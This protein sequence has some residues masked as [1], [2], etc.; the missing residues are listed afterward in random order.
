MTKNLIRLIGIFAGLLVAFITPVKSLYADTD[1]V[2]TGAGVHFVWVIF[3]RLNCDLE[4]VS[5][6]SIILHGRNSTLGMGCNAD[7]KTALQNRPDN[8]TFG[9][10]CCPLS[11]G[12]V[13]PTPENLR[14]KKYPFYRELSAVTDQHPSDDVVKIINEVQTGPVFRKVAAEYNLLPLKT[15][16]EHAP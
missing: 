10:V 15:A 12:G 11:V 6:R 2:I 16:R 5:G 14:L 8:E 3:D 7:I 1:N 4:E 9:M 13:M